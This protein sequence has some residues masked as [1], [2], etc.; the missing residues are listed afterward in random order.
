MAFEF[1]EVSALD[2]SI[3]L[4]VVHYNSSLAEPKGGIS[5]HVPD[6]RHN[7]LHER[8]EAPKVQACILDHPRSPLVEGGTKGE[9]VVSFGSSRSVLV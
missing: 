7:K 3:V 1:V 2:V 5:Q 6:K 4:T 9:G 8:T